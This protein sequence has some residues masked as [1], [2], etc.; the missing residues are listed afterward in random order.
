[1]LLDNLKPILSSPVNPKIETDG[2]YRLASVLVVIYGKEPIIIMTEKPKH[3]KFHAGE[4]SFPGGKL[5]VNDS[6]LLQTALRE[7]SEE[8]G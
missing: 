8:I 4:I 6:D 1:M 5:D 2:K 7:T 3:M